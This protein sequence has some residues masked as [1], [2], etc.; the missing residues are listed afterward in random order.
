MD[1]DRKSR[2]SPFPCSLLVVPGLVPLGFL[3]ALLGC[4]VIGCRLAAFSGP[5]V[6]TLFALAAC[7]S[8]VLQGTALLSAIPRLVA[9]AGDRTAANLQRSSVL[10]ALCQPL[11]T[12]WRPQSGLRRVASNRHMATAATHMTTKPSIERTVSGVLHTPPA[13]V[14]ANRLSP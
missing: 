4:G 14:H 12:P 11:L 3:A 9:S 8:L 7:V 6:A 1:L 10:H 2:P 13:A 5:G